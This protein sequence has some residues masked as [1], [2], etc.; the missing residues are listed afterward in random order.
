MVRKFSITFLCAL[1]CLAASAAPPADTLDARLDRW[2]AA[3]GG[4]ERLERIRGSHLHAA[5]TT[6]GVAG[7]SETW[8]TRDGCRRRFAEG[9]DRRED[10]RRGARA[11]ARDWNGKTLEVR[12]RDLGDRITDAF[13]MSL[14]YAGFSRRALADAGARD[15]GDDST[16]ALRV[17]RLAPPG[18]IACDLY[19]DKGSG[20]PVRAVRKPYDDEIVVAFEDWR[21]VQG[22]AM[23]FRVL[24]KSGDD[25]ADT[26][27]VTE[28]TAQEGRKPKWSF[29]PPLDPPSDVRFASGDRA[30][31]IP[32]NFEN[33]HIMVECSVNGRKPIWFMFDTGADVTVINTPRLAELGLSAFGT[34]T[35][36]GGGGSTGFAFTHVARLDVGGASLL[37]QRNGV[38]DVSGLE[39]IYGMPMGGVLGYDF[40]SRFVVVVDYGKRTMSL[41]ANDAKKERSRGEKVRFVL[42]EGHPHVAGSIT[43]DDGGPIPADFIIDSGA[44]ETANLTTP[45]V[46][47][48]RLLE[49]ARKTPAPAPAVIPGT[50]KQFFSQT[51]VRGHLRSLRLGNVTLTDIPVNLQQGTSGVYASA[52]FSGTIGERIL[53]RFT[54]TYDYERSVIVLDPNAEYSKPFPPR[55]TFGLSLI[56]DG[57]D[58]TTFKVTAV[59][60]NSPAEAAGFLTGDVFESMDDKPAS[61]W[62]LGAIRAALAADGTTHSVYVARGEAEKI[63]IGFKVELVSI[64]D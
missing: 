3:V 38:I 4:W 52:T 51:T 63:R 8:I 35:T 49:R 41:Y 2:A 17:V 9:D 57:P 28:I 59:R 61:S 23:P 19:L 20:L 55:T 21:P 37:G 6:S 43:V 27:E 18:G 29:A 10:V 45:F 56:S 5:T 22:V 11:W 33:D 64:E 46:R 32:F 40:A 16:G 50:E 14:V 44:A 24:V 25:A 30:L 1:L 53:Q 60:K 31:G 12:G 7:S 48:N 26:S 13:L 62:R 36:T 54:T 34:T 15:G 42:E 47:A 58:F 39:R